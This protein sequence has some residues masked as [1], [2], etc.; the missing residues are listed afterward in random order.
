[1]EET[2]KEM[3]KRLSLILVLSLLIGMFGNVVMASA[4]SS[5][6]FKTKS[7]YTVE[8]GGT[9]NMQKNEFQ[10]FNLYK[11]GSEI[12]Q[13][14]SRYTV[15]WSSSDETVIWIDAKNGKAR[16]DKAKTM[17]EEYGEATIT[18]KIRNKTTGAVAYRSF[19]VTVGTLIPEA[20]AVDYLV[21]QFADGTDA[22]QTLKMDTVY[23]LE[24]IAYDDENKVIPEEEVRL[25]YAYFCDDAGIT[26]TG[27]SFKAT[28]DG[29][30]TII[31]AGFETEEE[32]EVA[33]SADDAIYTAELS[34]L[35][36]EANTAKI[37]NIRQVDLCT[38]ALTFNKPE[39]AKALI[40]NNAL[41]SVTYDI[42]GAV[43][44][45]NFQELILD[46]D[47]PST[48]TV[49]LYSSLVEGMTYTFTYQ[50]EKPVTASVTGSGTTPAKIE[51]VPEKVE[52]ERYY[53]FKVKVYNDKDV[54]ITEI[55]TETCTFEDL[56]TD[57]VKPYFVDG[58]TLYFFEEG[59]TA[60]VRATMD[61]GYDI[62]GNPIAVL[63]S[64]AR[65]TSIPKVKPVYGSCNGFSIAKADTD[66]ESLTY[67]KTAN[68]ICAGDT[69]LYLYATF[70]YTDEFREPSTRY[71]VEGQDTTE[72]TPYTYK[73]SNE[74]V[75]AVDDTTG[76]L[77]PFEKGT[78]YV[79]IYN[80]ENKRIG[81]VQIKV[82]GERELTTFS[83]TNQSAT[84]LS[85]FGTTSDD[86]SEAQVITV[87]LNAMDQLGS[88]IEADYSL[89]VT[90]PTGSDIASLFNYS[91]EDNVLTIWEGNELT[92][93]V[94]TKRPVLPFTIEVTAYNGEKSI[95]REVKFTVKN[96]T[97]ATASAPKL[98]ISKTNVDLKLDK[99][100]LS[101]Y[102]SVIQVVTTDSSG[103][104]I[105]R[106]NVHLIHNPSDALKDK[107]SYSVLILYKGASVD[108]SILPIATVDNQLI[109]KP[110]STSGGNEIKKSPAG[111]YTI[112]LYKGDGTLA[113]PAGDATLIL[114]DSTPTLNV[115][116]KT[117]EIADTN[118]STLKN[119]LN[120]KRGTVDVSSQVTIAD[121]ESRKVNSIYQI[122]E[123]VLHIKAQEF[124]SDWESEDAY[125]KVTLSGL[126]LQFK[127]TY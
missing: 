75:L 101:D 26:L 19:N 70:P 111:T 27:S 32:A 1:M 99:A 47:N 61:L 60:T 25:Y 54:D 85:A 125:T 3:K 38:V 77:H 40:N 18:A 126:N 2:M 29:E 42:S 48:V 46:E 8:V 51:L 93:T 56:N 13:K 110:V 100:N 89:E 66:P 102:E 91:I 41:L 14:D 20:P 97:E 86:P 72:E 104:F 73:S 23:E 123:L 21:L 7:G 5:W 81:S 62:Y 6:S 114:S 119:A 78:A 79:Y 117:R 58:S 67:I 92:E 57:F 44:T 122:S 80:E 116:I 95:T 103:Y 64:I 68:S 120:F 69:G 113:R 12:T 49:P 4:A 105:R 87:K 28:K 43:Y 98:S 121:L 39:Y 50:G 53:T 22:S 16:A 112:R 107:N 10:D 76:E 96:V 37:T 34:D 30:Y 24:T 15:T 94:T 74:T 83:L 90:K 71:I 115:S 55:T 31:V 11:S 17:T 124:N 82:S 106:E 127:L 88:P 9:I 52:V 35:I 33:T 108:D 45:A 109:L 84:K 118:F 36:V 59:A 63:S 65:F